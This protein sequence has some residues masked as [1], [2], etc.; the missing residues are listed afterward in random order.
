VKRPY[1]IEELK[2]APCHVCGSPA[3]FQWVACAEN[4]T[5]RAVCARHDI[6]L[7]IV[8]MRI[9]DPRRWRPKVRRYA[10]KIGFNRKELEKML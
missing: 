6:M 2:A 7:N 8:T 4:G 9:L 10:A 5:W 1:S 3:V